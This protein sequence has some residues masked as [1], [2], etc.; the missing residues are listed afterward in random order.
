MKVAIV[1][2]PNTGK[3]SL[4]NKLTGLN[5]KVGNYPG[6]TVEKK[7]GY[8]KLENGTKVE[9]IDLPGTYSLNASSKDEEIVAE[10]LICKDFEDF[11]EAVIVVVDATNLKRNLLL[12]TQ[13]LDLN[14]P[15][16]LV[17]NMIDSVA[18]KGLQID[19]KGISSHFNVPVV[20]VNARK[21]VG[22]DA[23][24][25]ALEGEPRPSTKTIF[26]PEIEFK[27]F[28]QQACIILNEKS[29]YSA[30]LVANTEDFR[31]INEDQVAQL[32]ALRKKHN[33]NTHRSKVKET[34][35]RYREIDAVISKYV[36]KTGKGVI[37]YTDKLDHI[38]THKIWG[39]VFFFAILTIIFQAI[40]S[41]ASWPMEL[42]ETIFADLSAFITNVLPAGPVAEMLADGV[43]PGV[44]GVL[45]FIPQIAIL[46]AF[47][48]LLEETGYMSRVVFI[49]DKMLRRFGMNGKSV[50]PLLSGMACA[51]PAVMA[52]RNI[53]NWKERLITILVTPFMTC[54]AR[55]PVYTILIALVIP[56]KRLFGIVNLQGLVLMGLYLFGFVMAILA[57]YVF[58]L[59]LKSKRKSY[60]IMEMPPYKLPQGR[61][62]L[63]TIIEKV[64]SF[65]FTAGKIIVAISIVLWLLASYGPNNRIENAIS[66]VEQEGNASNW[67]EDKKA[68]KLTAAR[69]ENS[70]IG[71]FGKSIEPAIKP[72][73]YDWKIG[74]A[75]ISSFAARE[76]FV[77]TMA[78]I[79]SVGDKDTELGVKAQMANDVDAETGEHRFNLAVAFSLLIFYALAMQCMSTMAVVYRET[80]GWKWP[81]IQFVYMTGLAYVLSLITYQLMK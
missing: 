69:L 72:L 58:S 17:L 23:L 28:T 64:K 16:V 4:F 36:C 63:L 33:I 42:I 67:T 14:L 7:V 25:R 27:E 20:E 51:I 38:F 75:L 9:L 39:F 22:V 34:V 41:W 24:K 45:V 12:F 52:T 76:V 13:V 65:V 31:L 46:F 60:L 5:Q 40:F 79:Y 59:I 2:N 48:A 26:H 29:V 53:S 77:G 37:G 8:F 71:I 61:N 35:S 81:I 43:V 80:N 32:A 50:V 56:S 19:A 78:T 49:M 3:T 10:A 68:L 74:I 1:G 44:A 47:I 70:Y 30:W 18:R 55:L 6:I 57:A 21:G 11:P 73:G 62:V 66:A 15:V 54:S